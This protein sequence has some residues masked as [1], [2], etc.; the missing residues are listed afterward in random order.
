MTSEPACRGGPWERHDMNVRLFPLR[1]NGSGVSKHGVCA[2]Q[3]RIFEL[4]RRGVCAANSKAIA[5]KRQFLSVY[6]T[7]S[8]TRNFPH[9]SR[10]NVFFLSQKHSRLPLGP[11]GCPACSSGFLSRLSGGRQGDYGGLARVT[12]YASVGSAAHVV[13]RGQK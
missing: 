6:T 5:A 12:G 2:T 4:P 7:C 13:I 1:G 9:I 8:K 10:N 11:K 3:L